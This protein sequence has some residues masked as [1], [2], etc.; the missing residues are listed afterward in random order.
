MAVILDG[1]RTAEVWRA[2][3][4]QR[5]DRLRH[6]AGVKPG[7]AVVRVGEDPASIVYV[8]NKARA[9]AEAGI[10]SVVVELEAAA[11]PGALLEAIDRLAGDPAIHGL[12]VQLPLP[13]GYDPEVIQERVPPEKDVDGLHPMNQ[14]L[15]ALGRPR[16]V[17]ATPLGI[18][19]LLRRY[20][21]PIAGAQVLVIG[22]SA[23]VGRPLA[24]LLGNRG[25]LGD[26]TVTVAHSQSR[27]LAALGRAAD[28]LVAAIGRPA[29]VG[30]DLVR[31]GAVVIDVGINRVQDP[32]AKG[33]SRL[34]GDV[35]FTAVAPI[36][37]AITP[38]P[39]GVGPMTI[40][41]LVHNTLVAAEQAAALVQGRSTAGA[42]R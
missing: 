26:A 14:G 10:H 12:L 25:P 34:V 6:E 30:A 41:G 31:P 32:A 38:V 36:A 27:G 20:A 16:F 18:V 1:K 37:A 11:G 19:E 2:E 15:L 33:G 42:R 40:A 24:T 23:I 22:R 3:L 4:K 7:L 5:V 21:I 39:G 9:A 17:P 8:R 28:I 29:F 13:K 35:D